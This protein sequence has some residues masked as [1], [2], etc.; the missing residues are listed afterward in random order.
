MALPSSFDW[1]HYSIIQLHLKSANKLPERRVCSFTSGSGLKIGVRYN[2]ST[3][4]WKNQ[5]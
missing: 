1:G 4:D 2:F 5:V 3:L